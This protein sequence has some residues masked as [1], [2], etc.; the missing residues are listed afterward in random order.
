M[1]MAI[2]SVLG[3]IAKVKSTS[4]V[5][6]RIL[7]KFKAGGIHFIPPAIS[8]AISLATLYYV[9]NLPKKTTTFES[10]IGSLKI[11]TCQDVH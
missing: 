2:K 1:R 10:L 7:L 8:S 5:P 4:F 9:T 11:N 3:K 6:S